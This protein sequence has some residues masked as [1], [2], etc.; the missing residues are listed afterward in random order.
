LFYG[1]AAPSGAALFD[2]PVVGP[3]SLE[4]IFALKAITRVV[5]AGLAVEDINVVKGFCETGTG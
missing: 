3:D 4:R 5:V 2:E 1:R